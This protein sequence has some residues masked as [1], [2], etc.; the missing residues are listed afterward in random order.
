M[1]GE[2]GA[3]IKDF[4]VKLSIALSYPDLYEIGM[5][6]VGVRILYNLL[7][8]I[9]EAACE[10]VFAPDKDFEHELR[11]LGMP[12]FSLET[13]KPLS[14]FDFL[15]FSVGYE[16]TYTNLLNII[17]MGGISV[18]RSERGRF[19]PIVVAGGPA[20]TNPAPLGR[21]VDC[22]YIGEAE[23]WVYPLFTTLAEMKGKGAGRSELLQHLIEQP[24]IWAADKQ[25]TARRAVWQGFGMD[26][27]DVSLPVPNIRTVQDNGTVEIMRGCPNGCRFCHAGMYYRPFR[28]KKPDIIAAEVE[29][30]VNSSGYRQITLASLSSGDY[31]N[32]YP[33][34]RA[35]NARY[36]TINASFALPSL[37][38]TGLALPVLQELSQ[39]RKSGLTL[40]V[41]TPTASW[42][43]GINKITTLQKTIEIL[44]EAKKLGWNKV[45]FYFM[46]GLPVSKGEDEVRPIVDFLQDAHKAT[47]MHLTA[48]VA[49]FIPK[50]HTPYQWSEQISEDEGLRRIMAIKAGLR[51]KWVRV[52]YH[53]PFV[54]VLEGI[55]ARGDSRLSELI[56]AA[57]RKGARLDAWEEHIDW[58][59]WRSI[60]EKA[61]WDVVGDTLR[62]KGLRDPLPW[63]KVD[64]G[65]SK[66]FL[67][68][69]LE[70]SE[71]R[72]TSE[73]CNNPCTCSCGV[74]RGGAEV[75]KWDQTGAIRLPPIQLDTSNRQKVLI[76]LSKKGRAIYCS[77][78]DTAKILER[79]L[80]R[81]GYHTHFSEGYNPKPRIEFASPLS[82]GIDSEEEIVGIELYNFDSEASFIRRVSDRLPS[83]FA[84]VRVKPVRRKTKPSLMSL[85]WGAD[86]RI[87]CSEGAQATRKLYDRLV[88]PDAKDWSESSGGPVRSVTF[89][90]QILIRFRNIERKGANL[91]G[92]LSEHVGGHALHA[93]LKLK[94]VSLWASVHP[95]TPEPEG[96]RESCSDIVSY[97]D[98]A[99]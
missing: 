39:V 57:F 83:G 74:C 17:D 86:Y 34:V 81:A 20:A 37:K 6:N 60:I 75:R 1:G 55:M 95:P 51:G 87:A 71:T 21:F 56:L 22:V 24:F 52:K 42:Q 91:V 31:G 35:L 2:Y 90:G 47:G 41:E 93:G 9:P 94:R 4:P 25:S 89:D 62:A 58:A 98:Y 44:L 73:V 43:R 12:L 72:A 88:H 28:M 69:E 11:S 50:P 29:D 27:T 79:S 92:Y 14:E 96:K 65:V 23:A 40:A 3:V 85:L 53:S 67:V 63:S 36:S 46:V 15:L 16:L 77:H 18:E 48:N 70:K 61:P 64:L 5:S 8:S 32:L 19:D 38:I 80:L 97:F 76:G 78:L 7:N 45:K 68:R 33:L 54:S 59:L 49:C 66:A 30:L 82:L 26:P 99:F 13:T 84:V 10:R